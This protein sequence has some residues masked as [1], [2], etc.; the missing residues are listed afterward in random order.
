M[1]SPPKLRVRRVKRPAGRFPAS[2]LRVPGAFSLRETVLS[3]GWYEL[4]PFRWEDGSASL[5]RAELLPDG[6]RHL[7]RFRQPG[8]VGRPVIV[9]WTSG[10]PTPSRM[11][12]LV[13][14]IR[15]ILSLEPDL[16]EFLALCRRE[17]R[18]RYVPRKGA[19]RF[20]RCGN[21]FEEV[22]KG[23][24]GTNIAWRQAVV[25]VNRVACFGKPVPGFSERTFPAADAVLDLG[26]ARLK[27][28]SRLGYRVPYL[29]AWARRVADGDPD[30]AG[31]E[32]GEMSPE[33]MKRFLLSVPGVGKATA[34]YLLMIWGHGSE[35]SVD[36]SVYLYCRHN[37]FGGRTPTEGEI[38]ALY[39]SYGRWKAHAYW[40]EFL[41]WARGHW[42]LAGKPDSAAG[43][44]RRPRAR[45]M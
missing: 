34:R 45:G 7:F 10:Q 32:S 17:P 9:S 23:I 12:E 8:G 11:A 24:C 4:A 14:R 37:R 42:G 44:V 30:Y 16:S 28:I 38:L 5:H 29:L 22:F 40:F 43:R 26:E 19:G 3:H 39:D 33:D 25:A 2:R 27:E 31:V 35:I 18:L 41:P 20:L 6:S 21:L 1:K 15:R 36:S 13:D